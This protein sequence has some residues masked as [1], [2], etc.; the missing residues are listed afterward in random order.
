M[1]DHEAAGLDQQA[2]GEGIAAVDGEERV[3]KGVARRRQAR[4]TDDVLER[5]TRRPADQAFDFSLLQRRPH[6]PPEFLKPNH[7]GR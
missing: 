6:Q 5:K 3:E 4:M 2:N 7:C 1:V